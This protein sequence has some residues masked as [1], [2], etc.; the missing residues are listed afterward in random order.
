MGH[1]L[2]LD[3]E[4]VMKAKARSFLTKMSSAYPK[5]AFPD[6]KEVKRATE[7]LKGPALT[8]WYVGAF[9]RTNHLKEN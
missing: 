1:D 6:K 7:Q 2:W 3:R 8:K 4:G 9:C 5:G